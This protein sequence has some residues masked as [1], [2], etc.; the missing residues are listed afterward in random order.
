MDSLKC[1]ICWE[2]ISEKALLDKCLHEFCLECILEW[3]KKSNQ[4]P[5]CRTRFNWIRR[6]D[7]NPQRRETR[8]NASKLFIEDKQFTVNEGISEDEDVSIHSL[9]G[10]SESASVVSSTPTARR[11]SSGIGTERTVGTRRIRRARRRRISRRTSRGNLRGSRNPRSVPRITL[12]SPQN[13]SG[14]STSDPVFTAAR[15]QELAHERTVAMRRA[16]LER[17]CREEES[18]SCPYD[19]LRP[20]PQS[21]QLP[22][23]DPPRGRAFLASLLGEQ[24]V[25][26]PSSRPR[27]TIGGGDGDVVLSNSSSRRRGLTGGGS[28]GLP[29]PSS[30]PRSTTTTTGIPVPHHRSNHRGSLTD[31][32]G[33]TISHH[34]SSCPRATTSGASVLPHSSSKFHTTTCDAVLPSRPRTSA[35]TSIGDDAS[36]SAKGC[37]L[38]RVPRRHRR[39]SEPCQATLLAASSINSTVSSMSSVNSTPTSTSSINPSASTSVHAELDLAPPPIPDFSSYCLSGSASSF[40]LPKSAANKLNDGSRTAVRGGGYVRADEE[41]VKSADRKKS[42]SER[43]SSN[44][45][46]F[47][48]GQV[49]VGL[50]EP[51]AG[52]SGDRGGYNEAECAASG[53]RTGGNLLSSGTPQHSDNQECDGSDGGYS[54]GLSR[55]LLS[56]PPRR[57]SRGHGAR[58]ALPRS[59]KDS[60][61]PLVK[62]ALRPMLASGALDRESFK[63]VAR[64]ATISVLSRHHESLASG[65]LSV[66]D[67]LR[68]AHRRSKIAQYVMRLAEKEVSKRQNS[69]VPCQKTK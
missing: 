65:T 62:C 29:L 2:A 60:L 27:T 10:P 20:Q 31:H 55:E 63:N 42:L 50:D 3:G 30:R 23:P 26:Q 36:H 47:L 6:N 32:D 24:A 58:D 15:M 46:V 34:P 25:S 54:K 35:A 53:A 37:S 69:D 51:A 52:R 57:L 19:N 4:C 49:S 48:G 33:D 9:A 59:W 1:P 45:S 64:T 40:S 66:S 44:G 61:L 21:P 13:R 43:V 5:L 14:V 16:E 56:G 39:E 8:G 38:R 28:G 67:L 12:K 7:Y 22:R 68:N 41:R 18:Q 11:H 17:R